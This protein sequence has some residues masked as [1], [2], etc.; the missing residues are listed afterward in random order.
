[1][2]PTTLATAAAQHFGCVVSDFAM[3]S[4][5]RMHVR[6]RDALVLALR[7]AE[8]TYVEAGR[9]LGRDHS[10]VVTAFARGVRLPDVRRDAE[11]IWDLASELERADRAERLR[12]AGDPDAAA[13]L[14][15]VVWLEAMHCTRKEAAPLPLEEVS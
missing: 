6:R 8:V 14:T 5:R 9:L 2:S 13:A 11:E 1:M 15:G 3:S 7:R 10:S 12:L 4:R